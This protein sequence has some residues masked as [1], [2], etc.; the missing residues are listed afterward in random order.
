MKV[1]EWISKNL[2]G[3]K[4]EFLTIELEMDSNLEV[5]NGKIY[6][7][8]KEDEVDMTNYDNPKSKIVTLEGLK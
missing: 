1:K 6:P 7:T 2:E 4:E 3:Y 5:I 8:R